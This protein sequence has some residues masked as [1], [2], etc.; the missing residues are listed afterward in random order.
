MPHDN[1]AE[2]LLGVVVIALAASAAAPQLR[3]EEVSMIHD[4]PAGHVRLPYFDR[5]AARITRES[6]GAL[7]VAINP[8]ERVF[9]GKAGLEAVRAGTARMGWVNTAHIEA[10]SPRV[11]VINLPFSIDDRV[12]GVDSV[13]NGV[14]EL[15]NDSLDVADVRVIGLM[16]AADQ[17]FVFRDRSLGGPEDLRGMRIRVAGTG[18][19]ERIMESF[20]AVAVTVPP[21]EIRAA[22]DGGKVDGVFTS[23]GGWEST[24]GLSAPRASLVPGLMVIT[25]SLVV[26]RAWYDALPDGQRTLLTEAARTKVTDRWTAMRDDDLRLIDH[27]VKRGASFTEVTPDRLAPWKALVAPVTADF[28]RTHPETARRLD[29]L[30]GAAP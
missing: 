18:V 13:R 5:M 24:V 22:V 10:V 30:V 7:T 19:Y 20:G 1:W 17:V 6:A 25:Y 11:G 12:M 27:M 15:I 14:V 8:G 26:N 21:R 9:L 4:I 16:R 2:R 3:A 28:R 23:P 29:E